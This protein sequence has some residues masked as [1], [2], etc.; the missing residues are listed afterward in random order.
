MVFSVTE[1]QILDHVDGDGANGEFILPNSIN[2]PVCRI[3][4]NGQEDCYL[5]F[6]ADTLNT[7][8]S[9]T[10]TYYLPA[11]EWSDVDKSREL[12]FF[13]T[14]MAT[15]VTQLILQAGKIV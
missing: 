3:H 13:A 2:S 1:L 7:K 15:G 6:G 5:V 8:V 11:G 10:R 9:G 14:T 12:K 4:N